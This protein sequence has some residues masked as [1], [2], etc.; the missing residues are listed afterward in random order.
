MAIKS[1]MPRMS[2]LSPSAQILVSYKSRPDTKL[3]IDTKLILAADLG[4]A[5]DQ[6][7]VGIIN[8]LRRETQ[9]Q[10]D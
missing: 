8:N 4:K 10:T 1:R 3:I 6:D 2:P 5:V 7:L 9:E